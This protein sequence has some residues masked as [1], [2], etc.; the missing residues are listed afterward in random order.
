MSN[1][2]SEISEKEEEL[3]CRREIERDEGVL[4]YIN[5][6]NVLSIQDYQH[7]CFPYTQQQNL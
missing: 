4:K 7:F 3:L 2:A 1:W 5:K 6:P